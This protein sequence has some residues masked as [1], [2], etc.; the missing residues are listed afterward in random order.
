MPFSPPVVPPPIL[1]PFPPAGGG[2]SVTVITQFDCQLPGNGNGIF[3]QPVQANAGSN[4]TISFE[5]QSNY[6]YLYQGASGPTLYGPNTVTNLQSG[7]SITA[8]FAKSTGDNI[9]IILFP[10]AP[11]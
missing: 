8:T 2:D 3:F 10:K 1:I 6:Y 5:N 4:V 11:P 9:G 7:S